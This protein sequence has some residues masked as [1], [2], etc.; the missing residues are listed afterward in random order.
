MDNSRLNVSL[1]V[2]S[3]FLSRDINPHSG[4]PHVIHLDEIEEYDM[5]YLCHNK[6]SIRVKAV[7]TYVKLHMR[8]SIVD[9]KVCAHVE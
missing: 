6:Y 5:V 7:S 2:F 8:A 1:D 9:T 3:Y 4:P